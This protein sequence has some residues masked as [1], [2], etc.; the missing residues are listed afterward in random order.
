MKMVTARR[1]T[2][3]LILCAVLLSGIVSANGH[4]RSRRGVEPGSPFAESVLSRLV[5][6][7]GTRARPKLLRD[8]DED[9]A[10]DII[11]GAPAILYSPTFLERLNAATKTPWAA[12]G[13][14]A[15]E[16]GHHHYGHMSEDT[17]ELT[18]AIE[19]QEELDA[20]Y[21]SGY[22]L[23]RLGASL[24][25]AQA[26]LDDIRGEAPSATHPA[27]DRRLRMTAVGWADGRD[28][29]VLAPAPARRDQSQA[30]RSDRKETGGAPSHATR[31]GTIANGPW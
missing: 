29:A 17:Y 26:S 22:A 7:T 1:S 30:T 15:H 28:D 24:V 3:H 25:E 10:S 18:P 2:I 11:D 13:V 23:A 16:L 19:R 20:D 6:A 5:A 21:F 12:V 31:A 14:I 8:P 27:T 4:E 9:A